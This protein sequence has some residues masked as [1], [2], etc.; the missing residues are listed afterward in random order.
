MT[1]IERDGARSCVRT[2]CGTSGETIRSADMALDGRCR[3]WPEKASPA[4]LPGNAHVSAFRIV[5]SYM[6][7]T[8]NRV[9]GPDQAN[10]QRLLGILR[11]VAARLSRERSAREAA[12]ERG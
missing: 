1:G 2:F 4:S 3:S 6:H 5:G 7:M 9:F 12:N 11:S 8:F 10:E